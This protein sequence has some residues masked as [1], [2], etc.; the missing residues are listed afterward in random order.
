VSGL[1]SSPEIDAA[2]NVVGRPLL[3]LSEVRLLYEGVARAVEGDTGLWVACW[4]E[5][6][7]EALEAMRQN[8]AIT[9]LVDASFPNGLK[10]VAQMRAADSS[11]RIV[12]FAVSETEENV[13]AW[14]QAGAAG[15][16]PATAA[17]SEL[18][19]FIDRILRG[20]QICSG[21]VASGLMR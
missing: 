1:F 5:D 17:L 20:E 4:C 11:A 10:A 13:I 2:T 16:I 6:L 18:T 21:N 15:Y 14:A 7:A 19:G 3:V 12:V 9:I 8:P